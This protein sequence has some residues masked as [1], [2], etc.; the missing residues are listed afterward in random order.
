MRQGIPQHCNTAWPE[1]GACA[2]K[3]LDAIKAEGAASR[4]A[5]GT[6]QLTRD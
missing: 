2:R 6:M 4:L 1:R 3:V 5:G